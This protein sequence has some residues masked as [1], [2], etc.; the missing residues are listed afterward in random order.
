MKRVVGG[1]GERWSGLTIPQGFVLW[2][3][4][5]GGVPQGSDRTSLRAAVIAIWVV[6]PVAGLRKIFWLRKAFPEL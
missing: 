6:S 2:E 5:G 3:H 4:L 1:I